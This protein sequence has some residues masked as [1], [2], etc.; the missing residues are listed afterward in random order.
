MCYCLYQCW[1]SFCQRC[2]QNPPS[3]QSTHWESTQMG[4]RHLWLHNNTE[5]FLC[6][7]QMEILRTFRPSWVG[8]RCGQEVTSPQA[9]QLICSWFCTNLRWHC[10]GEWMEW[11]DT[12]HCIQTRP[13]K[14]APGWVELVGMTCYPSTSSSTCPFELTICSSHVIHASASPL[15][16]GPSPPTLS[17]WR[18]L[19]LVSNLKIRNTTESWGCA[20]IG[21]VRGIFEQCVLSYLIPRPPNRWVSEV[22]PW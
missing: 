1:V 17:L 5:S 18:S 4:H 8:Q 2:R 14:T 7:L 22:V 6:Q 3:T 12:K 19:E 11:A 16:Q 21:A 13:Q 9:R 20:C 15:C 10:S